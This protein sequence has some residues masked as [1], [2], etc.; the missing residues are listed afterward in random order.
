MAV[1]YN[2]EPIL[3]VEGLKQYFNVSRKF[4]KAQM[5]N[6]YRMT[7]LVM[8]AAVMKADG[9]IMKTE[10]DVVKKFLVN[11]YGKDGALEALQILKKLLEQNTKG[12]LTKIIFKFL[13]T[14]H[15]N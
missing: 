14:L 12:E 7:F 15:T 11:N 3:K 9:K 4:T 8:F 1:N 13:L 6:D 10:L 5:A 2:A